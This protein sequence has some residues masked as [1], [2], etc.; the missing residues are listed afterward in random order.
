MKV[1]RQM[2][3]AQRPLSPWD[4][5]DLLIELVKREFADRYRGSFGGLIWSFAQPLLLLTVYTL[6]FGVILQ[7]RWGLAGGTADY[8]L[9]LFAGLIVHNAFVECLNRAPTLVTAT[10]NLVKKIVFPLDLLP[11]VMAFT[12]LV[13]ALIAIAVWLLGFMLLHGLPCSTVLLVPLLLLCY[14]PFLLGIGWLLSA[15]GVFVRDIRQLTGLLSQVSFFLT[16]IFYSADTLPVAFQPLL[17]I[18]PLTFIVEQL[19]LVLFVGQVPTIT[20]LLAYFVL[21]ALFAALA[22]AFFQRLRP[23]FADLV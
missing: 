20:G 5:R 3:L 10:P 15:L 17:L 16:P 4:H 22:W 19:R 13:H 11:W 23:H 8:A 18:N 7:A 2:N 6:V 21:A 9:M 12:A 14:L 1:Q